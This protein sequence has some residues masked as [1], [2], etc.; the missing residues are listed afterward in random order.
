MEQ[1]HWKNDIKC[2]KYS[3][4]KLKV[5][6]TNSKDKNRKSNNVKKSE[7]LFTILKTVDNFVLIATTLRSVTLSIT[8]FRWVEKPIPTEFACGLTLTEKVL[9]EKYLP[10]NN[11][12]INVLR[13]LNKVSIVLINYVRKNYGTKK[14]TKKNKT[15]FVIELP[16]M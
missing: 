2:F 14:F 16:K 1:K 12:N 11:K 5:L 6:N 3:N 10:E 15:P 8:G 9:S 7:S 13:E 4:K